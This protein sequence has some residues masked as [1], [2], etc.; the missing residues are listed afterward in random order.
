MRPVKN[1]LVM[2]MYLATKRGGNDL[3]ASFMLEQ[4]R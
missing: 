1:L 2:G 3:T 4:L